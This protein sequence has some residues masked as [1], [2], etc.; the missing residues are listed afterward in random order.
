LLSQGSTGD[1]A[2]IPKCLALLLAA[3]ACHFIY[4]PNL[5]CFALSLS[6]GAKPA[7]SVAE[8]SKD[9]FGRF[10]LPQFIAW[11]IYL[12]FGRLAPPVIPSTAEESIK[13]TGMHQLHI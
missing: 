11:I 10:Y 9:L 4:P 7:L 8:V 3:G 12:S 2:A 6:K 13:K 1:D 5:S